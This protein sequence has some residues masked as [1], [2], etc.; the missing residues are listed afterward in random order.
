MATLPV[1]EGSYESQVSNGCVV[2]VSNF[3]K[4]RLYLYTVYVCVRC[5]LCD[6]ERYNHPYY[7]LTYMMLLETL[8]TLLSGTLNTG[9]A[10]TNANSPIF[11]Q[12]QE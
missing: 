6:P 7:G 8:N 4:Y 5:G 3:S 10:K 2:V 12:F 11:A 9:K 1:Y